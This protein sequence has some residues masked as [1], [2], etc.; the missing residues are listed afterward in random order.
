M[1]VV[2][3]RMVGIGLG[4]GLLGQGGTAGRDPLPKDSLSS[5]SSPALLVPYVPTDL[6]WTP[7]PC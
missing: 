1:W 3:I 6:Y 7:W 2:E 4:K 5:L